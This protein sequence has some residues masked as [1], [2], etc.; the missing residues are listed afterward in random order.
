MWSADFQ[1]FS[2]H[3]DSY[4]SHPGSKRNETSKESSSTCVKI[5]DLQTGVCSGVCGNC[6]SDVLRII[7]CLFGCCNIIYFDFRKLLGL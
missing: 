6:F 4:S 7:M 1:D 3:R 2:G 5:R